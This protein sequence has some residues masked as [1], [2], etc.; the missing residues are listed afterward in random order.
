MLLGYWKA[1]WWFRWDFPL[2]AKDSGHSGAVLV[3]I[4]LLCCMQVWDCAYKEANQYGGSPFNK[5]GLQGVLQL[6]PSKESL[7]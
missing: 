7:F 1:P 5:G 6:Q 4:S 2:N 3:D